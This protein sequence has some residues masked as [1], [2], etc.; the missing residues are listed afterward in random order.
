MAVNQIPSG[1]TITAGSL[2]YLP[3]FPP[4]PDTLAPLPLAIKSPKECPPNSR[5][6]KLPSETMHLK[7]IL[8][9]FLFF[10]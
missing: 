4:A 3:P 7:I 5:S 2:L 9:A 10:P 6:P 8:F 1:A